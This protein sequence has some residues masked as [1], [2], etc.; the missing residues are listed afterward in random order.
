MTTTFRRDVVAGASTMMAAF[1]TANPTLLVRHFRSR[2]EAFVEL[3]CTYL[4]VRPETITHS[5]GVR[6]R[7]TSPSIVAVTRLTEAGET[8]DL[9]DTLVDYLV[10]HFTDYPHIAAGT[11]WDSMTVA[12]EPTGEDNQFAA[13]RFT[14]NDISNG[15]GRN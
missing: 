9:H 7:T 10:D 5:N 4:D 3:P 14:F 8:S 1:I 2:P 6:V 15:E 13:T 12:D 11:V